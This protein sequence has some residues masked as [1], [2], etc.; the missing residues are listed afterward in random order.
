MQRATASRCRRDV[1]EAL[2]AL[3]GFV[4]SQGIVVSDRRWRQL[5]GLLRSAALTEGRDAVDML[6]LWL[7]PYVVAAQPLQ[8]AALQDW[9]VAEVAHAAPQDAPWLARAVEAFEK[10]LEIELSM[11]A[12]ATTTAPASSHWH[13]PSA[14]R[15]RAACC[16][17]SP[18]ALEDAM[19]RRWSPLHVAARLAQ[20]DEVMQR[21]GEPLGALRAQAAELQ[22][23]L[24][25][26]IWL[27]PSLA[28]TLRGNLQRTIALL[29]SLLARLVAV[30]AGFAAM[31]LDETLPQVEPEPVAIGA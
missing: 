27:P 15:A 23:A 5:V 10:Q 22:A 6:D 20:V 29:E 3:R 30:R 2:G 17:S 11:P 16:A 8:V 13:A 28:A 7:V 4:Q 26:R 31:L 18:S 24:D 19:R 25:G 12:E 1:V 9:F 21:A 14:A